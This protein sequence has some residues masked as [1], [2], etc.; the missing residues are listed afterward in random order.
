MKRI[1]A[2][3]FSE[4]Q[5][6]ARRRIRDERE[7]PSEFIDDPFDPQFCSLKTKWLM[8]GLIAQD[9]VSV[10]VGDPGAGKTTI[11]TSIAGHY[12]HEMPIAGRGIDPWR[13]KSIDSYALIYAAEDPIGVARSVMAWEQHN[14]VQA[15]KIGVV[16]GDFDLVSNEKDA[17]RIAGEIT[18]LQNHIWDETGDEVIRRGRDVRLV[19]IDTLSD[20]S[21]GYSQNDD[22]AMLSLMHH[23]KL[24]A[25]HTRVHVAIVHH[26]GA[27]KKQGGYGSTV[28][29][30]KED[31]EVWVSAQANGTRVCEIKKQR[32]GTTGDKLYFD[33]E[34]VEIELDDFGHVVK[35]TELV[36][37]PRGQVGAGNHEFI[38]GNAR[39]VLE[40]LERVTADEGVPVRDMPDVLGVSRSVWRQAAYKHLKGSDA[41]KRQAFSRAERKIIDAKLAS[42]ISGLICPKEQ[43]TRL[44]AINGGA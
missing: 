21:G 32:D 29:W 11:M 14:S 17:A 8:D 18:D 37:V 6:R 12:A 27:S 43:P 26:H 36:A 42:E 10:W 13:E 2:E 44:V 39:V 33:F 22:Q 35:Q 31:T 4:Q 20:V 34:E 41:A 38:E 1:S 40:A 23:A 30:R 19:I 16:G 15:G 5:W 25:E 3:D 24:I 7:S 9:Q 28:I